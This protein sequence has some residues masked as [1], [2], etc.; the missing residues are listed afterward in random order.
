MSKKQ[1]DPADQPAPKDEKIAQLE[2]QLAAAIK[3][4][5]FELCA[6][7]RN[8]IANRQYV[9]DTQNALREVSLGQLLSEVKRRTLAGAFAVQFAGPDNKMQTLAFNYGD[10]PSISA[11]RNMVYWQTGHE[12]TKRTA[13]M[14]RDQFPRENWDDEDPGPQPRAFM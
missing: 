4:E 2:K 12:I 10:T 11:C 8:E 5:Q 14:Y 3:A 9:V 13:E 7:L 6:E 1:P